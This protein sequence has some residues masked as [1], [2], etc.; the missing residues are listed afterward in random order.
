[1]LYS[2]FGLAFKIGFAVGISFSSFALHLVSFSFFHDFQALFPFSL[3]SYFFFRQDLM[4]R[5][6]QELLNKMKLPC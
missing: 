1:M 5:E 3:F 4:E 2:L 6:I